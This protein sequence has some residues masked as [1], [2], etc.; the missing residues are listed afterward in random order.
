MAL[1]PQTGGSFLPF[2]GGC[3]ERQRSRGEKRFRMGWRSILQFGISQP[4]SGEHRRPSAGKSVATRCGTHVSCP[5]ADAHA[6]W[7]TYR[8]KPCRLAT[9]P[10][11][12]WIVA[13]KLTLDW[14]LEQIAEWLKREFPAQDT[15]R[16]SQETIYRSLF[17]QA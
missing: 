6:W 5:E 2:V 15:M 12:Q 10:T 7:R 11:I 4:R 9:S 17:V 16:D 3:A 14:S 1:C 8:H 13:I